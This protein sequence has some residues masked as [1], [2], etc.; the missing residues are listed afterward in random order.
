MLKRIKR[1]MGTIAM[2]LKVYW[3]YRYLDKEVP[4]DDPPHLLWWA[5]EEIDLIEEVKRTERAEA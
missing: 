1:E 4:V 3:T 2:L 5:R